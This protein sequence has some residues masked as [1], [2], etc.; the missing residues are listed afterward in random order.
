M[1]KLSGIALAYCSHEPKVNGNRETMRLTRARIA[2]KVATAAKHDKAISTS[3]NATR[4]EMWNR[5][6]A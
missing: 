1:V 5:L 6:E 2:T 4:V 3:S